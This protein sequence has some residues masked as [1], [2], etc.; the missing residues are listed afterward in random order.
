MKT[1][2][3]WTPS[4]HTKNHSGHHKDSSHFDTEHTSLRTIIMGKD[5][6]PTCS[7]LH[8]A[9]AALQPLIGYYSGIQWTMELGALPPPTLQAR[10]STQ[11]QG[12]VRWLCATRSRVRVQLLLFTLHPLDSKQGTASHALCSWS[13]G[14]SRTSHRRNKA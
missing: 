5:G 12:V 1:G 7:P 4:R 10:N 13:Q 2:D 8:V 11:V 6:F 9:Q 3:L 14:A